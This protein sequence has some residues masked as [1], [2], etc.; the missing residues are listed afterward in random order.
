MMARSGWI[1][2]E[3]WNKGSY[4]YLNDEIDVELACHISM[5]FLKHMTGFN[6]CKFYNLAT[7]IYS[8]PVPFNRGTF[9]CDPGG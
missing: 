1:S 8:F 3:N 7:E 2:N 5:L 4:A 6:Q 9:L